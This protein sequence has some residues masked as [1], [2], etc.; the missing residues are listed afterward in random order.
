MKALVQRVTK[1]SVTI[2]GSVTGKIGPGFV[3]LIGVKYG[4][5]EENARFLANKTVNLR[6]FHDENKLMNRSIQDINGEILV[7]SQFTLY[8]DTQKGNRPSFAKAGKPELAE[9]LYDLYIEAITAELGASRV[10]TGSFG[11]MMKVAI[12]N[13]G[14]VTIELKTD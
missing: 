2:D 8:A 5:T 7:I 12:I 13:D 9:K 11:A 1:G 4:D 10:A 6:V 3:V 14:P